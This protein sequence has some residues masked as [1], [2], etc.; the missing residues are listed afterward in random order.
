MGGGVR[1]GM[2][3]QK[4]IKLKEA[5]SFLEKAKN[6]IS[7]VRDREQDDLDNCP[8]NLQGSERYVIMENAIDELEEAIANI[9]QAT[10]SVNNAM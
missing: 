7:S 6:L 1:Q 3:R 5:V 2:N 10:E 8:E 4:R 9:E